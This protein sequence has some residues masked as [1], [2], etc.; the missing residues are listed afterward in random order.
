MESERI[1]S[2]VH[3]LDAAISRD[4]A[5]IGFY[6][7]GGD[8]DESFV[9][10]NEKGYLRLG[11]E[12]LKGGLSPRDLTRAETKVDLRYLISDDSDLSFHYFE[13]SEEKVR[14]DNHSWK[15]DLIVYSILG[16]LVSILILAVVGLV[17]IVMYLV[18]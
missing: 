11:V 5:R 18:T 6:T 12:F 9:Q 16:I 2:L 7:Y 8:V 3:E 1:K 13:V 10:G 15:D 14:E 4:D 17:S